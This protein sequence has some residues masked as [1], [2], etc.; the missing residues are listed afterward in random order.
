MKK[1]L[2]M[3]IRPEAALL[4]TFQKKRASKAPVDE[5]QWEP[6]LLWKKPDDAGPGVKDIE[7][8]KVLCKVLRPHQ[9]EGVKFM[10]ECI[11]KMKP[12]DGA[13]MIMVRPYSHHSQLRRVPEIY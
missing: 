12:Y 1:T 6:L 9:R 7:V 10:F 5:E 8:D 4:T 11:M 13:G 3:K 2:G